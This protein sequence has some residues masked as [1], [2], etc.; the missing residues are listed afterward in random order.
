MWVSSVVFGLSF[1]LV[2][3]RKV[4]IYRLLGWGEIL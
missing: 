4:N 2:G 1:S 3:V